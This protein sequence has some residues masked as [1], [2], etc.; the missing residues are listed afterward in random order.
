MKSVTPVSDGYEVVITC[1]VPGTVNVTVNV[2]DAERNLILPATFVL[3]ITDA[4]TQSVVDTSDSTNGVND[5]WVDENSDFTSD[6]IS[7]GD[8]S[9][10]NT[11]D[12]LPNQDSDIIDDDG[13]WDSGDSNF[14]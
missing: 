8:N 10:N 1:K 13:G 5:E 9:A 7:A 6:T 2:T 14:Q 12:M 3:T 11:V 4:S